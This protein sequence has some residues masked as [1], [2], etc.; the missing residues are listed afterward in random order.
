MLKIEQWRNTDPDSTHYFQPFI[1]TSRMEESPSET[2][3]P[4]ENEKNSHDTDTYALKKH[5]TGCCRQPLLWVHQTTWQKQLLARYGNTISLI[6]ATY[7][8]TKY[9]LALFFNMCQDKCGILCGVGKSCVSEDE[10]VLV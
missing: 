8:T 6:N 5:H 3:P 1:N 4:P 10:G 2:A 9:E 7:K